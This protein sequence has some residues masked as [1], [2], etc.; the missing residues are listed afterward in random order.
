MRIKKTIGDGEI[1]GE[2]TLS[3][4]SLKTSSE[5][6]IIIYNVP[7]NLT[8]PTSFA[9]ILPIVG[10]FLWHVVNVYSVVLMRH[11]PIYLER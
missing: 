5:Q 10:E 2:S 8:K 9:C 1:V 4:R 7:I 11:C 3:G 6:F